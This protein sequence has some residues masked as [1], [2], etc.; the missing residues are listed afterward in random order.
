MER[1]HENAPQAVPEFRKIVW[2][3]QCNF[4]HLYITKYCSKLNICICFL[5]MLKLR[6]MRAPISAITFA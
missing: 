5:S 4:S 2:A 1:K 3:P 6:K